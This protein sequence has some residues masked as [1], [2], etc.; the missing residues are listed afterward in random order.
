MNYSG[1]P[2]ARLSVPINGLAKT[3]SIRSVQRGALRPEFVDGAA[4]VTLPLD[5]A[6]MLLIDP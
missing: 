5:I 4:V 3:K 2:V 6:D 1:T